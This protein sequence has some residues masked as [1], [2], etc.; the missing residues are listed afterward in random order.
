ME[1]HQLRYFLAVTQTG[2]FTAAAKQCNVSQPSLSIQIA[3]LEDELG[4]PLFEREKK[5]ARL[6]SRGEMFLPRANAILGEMESARKEVEA[7]SNLSMGSVTLGCLPTTGAHVLPKIL[8]AF[9]KN[10]PQISVQLKEESSPGLARNLEQG[11]VELAIVDEAGLK[12]SLEHIVLLKEDLLLALPPHHVFSQKKSLALKQLADEPFIL[13][14]PG[15]GFRQITLELF[16]KAGL[17]P[18]VVFE[19]DGIETV[20]ALVAAGLGFSVVPRMVAKVPKVSYVE[21]S[22][23]Q[24]SRTLGLA[25]RQKSKLSP[26]AQAL[27]RVIQETFKSEQV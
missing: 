10:Y 19:S 11:E 14:K 17:T 27:S 22:Q 12:P 3:K 24:A 9:R 7:L 18:Q 13:M 5:G 16:R 6:T 21:L 26:A 20:Q 2:R 23:P 1:T 15:H 8:T 25:W 4:G